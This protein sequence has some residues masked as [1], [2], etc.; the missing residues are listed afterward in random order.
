MHSLLSY[1]LRSIYNDL[2]LKYMKNLKNLIQISN[3][4][5]VFKS[6]KGKEVVALENINLNEKF[7]TNKN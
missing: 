2:S 1:Y 3:L 6:S 4:N 5:K 7:P